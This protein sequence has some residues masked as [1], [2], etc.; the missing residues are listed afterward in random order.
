[1]SAAVGGADG[2]PAPLEHPPRGSL[3]R[4]AIRF[5]LLVAL[6]AGV[7]AAL[8]WTPLGGYL[9]A[10]ELQRTLAALRGAWWS[11][12]ALVG[13]FTVCG[14]IGV[15]ATPFLVAGAAVF[16]P[17]T[18]TLWNFAG[19]MLASCAGFGLARLLGREFVERVGGEKIRRAERILHRRGFLPLVAVRFVPVPF[20]LVNAAAA[21]VGVRFGKFVLASAIGLLPPVAIFTYFFGLLVEAASGDRA[22]IARRMAAV[23]LGAAFVVFL[24]IGIRRRRRRRRYRRL[25][26]ERAARGAGSAG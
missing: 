20:Q 12:L 5:A 19:V 6:L 14:A 10:D 4:A 15:P 11:P 17:W 2:G 3:R 1:V 22:A 21:V 26:A 13:L 25:R 16:G 24:P 9:T 18:G 8:R 7:F 23:V